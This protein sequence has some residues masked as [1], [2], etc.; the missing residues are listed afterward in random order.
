MSV[1][2]QP[3][4]N[5]FEVC[6]L[7]LG[8]VGL[9]LA[10]ALSDIGYKVLGIE[11]NKKI[12]NQLKDGKPH[13]SE[14]GLED[15]LQRVI[16]DGFF[17]IKSDFDKKDT[18]N[19][20]IITV[21]TPLDSKGLPRHDFI[22]NA[23]K[24][25][26]GQIKDYDTVILRSTVAVGTTNKIV[27]PILKNVQKKF[28]ISMC[29]ERTLEGMALLELRSLPQIIGADNVVARENSSRLFRKLTNKIIHV[30][31][32]E[33][34]EVIKLVDNTYRDVN[35]AFGNEVAKICDAVGVRAKEIITAGKFGYE[36]TNVAMPG[37]VGGP[38][39][40]KDSHILIHS[41]K[42]FG[43][44]LKITAAARK[45]NEKQPKE[46]VAQ[47]KS[48]I[49]ILKT[50]QNINI[51]LA[52]IA[53][54]GTPET[55]DIRGSMSI[56]V[57]S[58]LKNQINKANIKL[59]DPVINQKILSEHFPGHQNFNKYANAIK[60]TDVLII[61]NNHPIFSSIHPK[62][63]KRLMNKKKS[64]IFDFW[65]HFSDYKEF[66]YDDFYFPLGSI[67]AMLGIE[68]RSANL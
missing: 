38:C 68:N 30:S 33:A 53:F 51:L 45:I 62:G 26:A 25:V 57:L 13:F 18:S 65:N 8:Y 28:Y 36:R 5:D 4:N 40:Q 29:P 44:D 34:A 58:E 6:I 31:S 59:Y 15:S 50:G 67:K 24:Q 14:K 46:A 39:L 17:T 19:Y 32:C 37:L 35:F 10:V 63:L 60:N 54:K 23:A 2:K 16:K 20:F 21:G 3:N 7:G 42:S 64:F 66:E 1:S 48:L 22:I 56:K 61:A 52:G 11:I 43:T 12:V 27:K 41:V 49:Q 55:D 9:T 47:I